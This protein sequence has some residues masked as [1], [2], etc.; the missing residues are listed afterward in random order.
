MKNDKH[1]LANEPEVASVHGP[2]GRLFGHVSKRQHCSRSDHAFAKRNCHRTLRGNHS[3]PSLMKKYCAR[4]TDLK[5]C[6]ITISQ[7]HNCPGAGEC[8]DFG[9]LTL[10]SLTH[11]VQSEAIHKYMVFKGY[12]TM[13]TFGNAH[14]SSQSR[15]S[16]R[17]PLPL[18]IIYPSQSVCREFS[19]EFLKNGDPQ[20]K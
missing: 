9:Y 15:P 3:H 18:W 13:Q 5:N 20:N 6:R 4:M 12:V 1:S 19:Q 7:L 11:H 10:S 17:S 2:F 8:K 16:G 14:F